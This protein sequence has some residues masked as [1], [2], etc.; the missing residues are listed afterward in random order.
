M[1]LLHRALSTLALLFSLLAIFVAPLTLE[2]VEG[3][4]MAVVIGAGA[5]TLLFTTLSMLT[6]PT[7]R[8]NAWWTGILLAL[9]AWI[10][11]SVFQATYRIEGLRWATL[12][13]AILGT[14]LGVHY[15]GARYANLYLGSFLLSAV[16]V[17]VYS[18]LQTTGFHLSVFENVYTGQKIQIVTGTY[19]NPSHLSGYLLL[20]SALTAGLVAFRK[21]DLLSVVALLI[22][23]AAQWINLKTDSSSI[24]VV[25]GVIPLTVVVWFGLRF[26][27]TVPALLVVGVLTV[28]AAGAF[29]VSDAGQKFYEQNKQT[30]GLTNTWQGFL[31]QRRDVWSYGIRMWQDHPVVGR[32][33]GQFGV[34]SPTYRRDSSQTQSPID[35]KYVNYT[36]SDFLQIGSE[37][38]AIGLVLF[39]LLLLA[40]VV[41]KNHHRPYLSGIAVVMV[42]GYLLTGI[43]ESHITAIPST[44]LAFYAFLGLAVPVRQDSFTVDSGTI[45]R[46]R[47][48]TEG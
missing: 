34:I 7:P 40:G 45:S 12:W 48:R 20:V 23:G 11:L 9:L 25:I 16:V 39:L 35:Q 1:S 19:F 18:Y 26:P 17:L 41:Q 47:L 44:M 33:I 3:W 6:D 31:Q 24:P 30:I 15:L 28:G 5:M 2:G 42:V 13:T 43:Y 22:L 10:W 36:H 32:G 38:G 29:V 14:A 27:R 37:L 4:G 8:A 46:N 21:L